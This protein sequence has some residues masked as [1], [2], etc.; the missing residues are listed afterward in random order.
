MNVLQDQPLQVVIQE[1]LQRHAHGVEYRERNA[2]HA[3][4]ADMSDQGVY[5]YQV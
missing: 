4:D 5:L 3:I 2:G 1:A